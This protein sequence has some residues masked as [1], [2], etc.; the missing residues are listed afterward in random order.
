MNAKLNVSRFSNEDVIATSFC[1]DAGTLHFFTT[2]GGA[3]DPVADQTTAPGI[4]Y[5]YQKPG[6]LVFQ[7]D[8]L[9]MTIPGQ[10]EIPAGKY[11]YFDGEGYVI[12]ENQVHGR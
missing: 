11:F 1:A 7:G 5:V 6:K 9:T 10:V 2:E 8:T 12:C 4:S 3:Y